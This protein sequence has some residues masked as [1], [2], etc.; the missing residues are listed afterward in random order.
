MTWPMVSA[1]SL[2][3][4]EPGLGAQPGYASSCSRTY[5]HGKWVLQKQSVG[6]VWQQP[7]RAL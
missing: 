4:E 3:M 2:T 7:S 6:Q 1:V 5:V